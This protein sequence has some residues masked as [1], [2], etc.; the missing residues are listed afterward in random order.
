MRLDRFLETWKGVIAENKFHRVATLVLAV[1]VLAAVVG[2]LRRDPVVVLV[3]PKLS[4]EVWISSKD[5]QIEYQKTWGLF[6]AELLGNVTPGNVE[7]LADA[8]SPLLS[9]KIHAQVIEAIHTQAQYILR[10]RV[11]LRFTPRSVVYEPE[12]RKVFVEGYGFISGSGNTEEKKEARTYEFVIDVDR[13]A[14]KVTALTVYDGRP[15]TEKVLEQE[16][17]KAEQKL[18]REKQ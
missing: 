1:A 4:E 3:P 16:A 11:S 17:S 2:L 8:V 9:P 18:R 15:K 7:F 13:Y 10:D 12:S 14:P 5:A 6:L